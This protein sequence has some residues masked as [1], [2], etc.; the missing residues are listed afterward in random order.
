MSKVK[1]AVISDIHHGPD[2]GSKR[3]SRA[4]GLVQKF[5]VWLS[6][7]PHDIAVELG[8][9]I[10][11]VDREADLVFVREVA[12]W[13]REIRIPMHHLVGNHDAK[14]LGIAEQE[15]ILGRPLQ[16]RSLDLNGWHLVFWSAHVVLDDA[17]GFSLGPDDLNWLQHDLSRT[18]L[19]TVL[20]THVP[21]DNG[22]MKGNFYFEKFCPHH[23]HYS[24]SEAERIR[25]VIER[26]QKVVLCIN[27][28]T[29][30]NAYHCID[31]VHYITI[32]SLTETF[33]TYPKSAEAWASII[34]DKKI[35]IKVFGKTPMKY[36]LKPK[37]LTQH[38]LNIE[39]DYS[40]KKIRPA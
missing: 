2:R 37:K 15:T 22:S 38:W 26:S 16:S 34:L 18:E 21:L 12:D 13:F 10:S 32:P 19:P 39:K 29:H 23:A 24:E 31:G 4:K 33:T 9:R 28:H 20:F 5:A 1:V 17:K 3:G 27:G 40:P 25:D 35:S 8:D 11:D 14:K 36:E 30:W 6:K 7:N